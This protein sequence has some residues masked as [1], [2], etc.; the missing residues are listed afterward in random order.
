MNVPLSLRIKSLPHNMIK[1][2]Y[3]EE[4]LQDLNANERL[5]DVGC[6]WRPYRK[7]YDRYVKVSYGIDSSAYGHILEGVDVAADADAIPFRAES[8]D[9]VFCTDVLEH[10]KWPSNAIKNFNAILKQKGVLVIAVPSMFPLH[11]EPFD[12]FRFTSHGLRLLLE[13]NGFKVI[14][15]NPQGEI[16]GVLV[17]WFVRIQ[18]VFWQSL[19]GFLRFPYF[20]SIFNP[21]VF[22]F[23]A[24]PQFSYALLAK[25]Y[26]ANSKWL[27]KLPMVPRIKHILSRSTIGYV[28]KAEKIR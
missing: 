2:H 24:I 22:V 7:M 10:L 3:L 25:F 19:G 16:I 14:K 13:E 5:V 1:R 8:F 17:F 23:M 4:C 26:I 6:G 15:M 27:A 28:V 12:Y 20:H 11:N 21:F 18:S 9:V